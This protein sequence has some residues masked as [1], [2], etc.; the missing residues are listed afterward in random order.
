MHEVELL[1]L[2]GIFILQVVALMHA[3]SDIE[4][5]DSFLPSRDRIQIKTYTLLASELTHEQIPEIVKNIEQHDSFATSQN[6]AQT[7]QV[8]LIY[9]PKD[10]DG[11][12][13]S[14]DYIEIV[15]DI[16]TYLLRNHGVI[17]DFNVIHGL[18]QRK[19]EHLQEKAQSLIY[20]PLYLGLF[21][22]M[23]GVV[24][25]L[26][27]MNTKASENIMQ[28]FVPSVA[29]AMSVSAVGLIMT[30]VM[31]Y[32]KLRKSIHKQDQNKNALITLLQIE[33]LPVVNQGMTDTF[34]Q[35]Q[36]SLLQFNRQFEQNTKTFFNASESSIK[37][38]KESTERMANLIDRNYTVIEKQSELIKTIDNARIHNITDANLKIMAKLTVA[39]EKFDQFAQYIDSTNSILQKTTSIVNALEE[40]IIQTNKL[41]DLAKKLDERLELSKNILTFL[42]KQ[43]SEIQKISDN[44]K[45]ALQ[46]TQKTLVDT[47]KDF[48]RIYAKNLEEVKVKLIDSFNKFSSIIPEF[49]EQVSHA[50]GNLSTYIQERLSTIEAQEKEM[51]QKLQKE[52]TH[53]QNLRYLEHMSSLQELLTQQSVI[54]KEVLEQLKILLSWSVAL[55]IEKS[56]R[57]LPLPKSKLKEINDKYSNLYEQQKQTL[58][59]KINELAKHKKE[60]TKTPPPPPSK[61]VKNQNSQDK[62]PEFVKLFIP[63]SSINP[64]KQ[65]IHNVFETTLRPES[66]FVIQVN[67]QNPNEGTIDIP[68]S[69]AGAILFHQDKILHDFICVKHNYTTNGICT[70]ERTEPGQVHKKEG[71][72][73]ISKP[74]EIYYKVV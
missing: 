17:A 39:L 63:V 23:A 48:E 37:A 65:C 66:C 31:S 12:Q 47:L 7:V 69:N 51:M 22:T 28:T 14:D 18:I 50:F 35:L 40:G 46:E 25:G 54:E 70:I 15:Q 67:T 1:V 64:Q 59:D 13:Y 61:P 45:I 11:K 74:I 41:T 53:L 20:A 68:M 58:Q 33:L 56:R 72:W 71:D 27:A 62:S 38:F 19:L 30:T 55:Q 34:L 9:L 5:F 60:Q 32:L 43:F 8:S 52:G 4:L 26:F 6:Q 73:Y 10:E 16:N 2:S 44:Q 29:I 21:G 36:R 24:F 42:D 49:Q 57:L 3:L